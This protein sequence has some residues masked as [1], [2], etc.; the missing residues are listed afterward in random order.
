MRIDSNRSI[1]T[2]RHPAYIYRCRFEGRKI[3]A[4]GITYAIS[5]DIGSWR[6]LTDSEVIGYLYHGFECIR[7]DSVSIQLLETTPAPA[8]TPKSFGGAIA[9]G[10]PVRIERPDGS[11]ETLDP[12]AAPRCV[13]LRRVPA[14]EYFRRKADSRKTYIRRSY[15]RGEKVFE[16]DDDSDISRSI[17]LKGS[18][19]VFVGF[20]Y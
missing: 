9:A 11:S 20:T 6:E 5:H 15:I 2:G 8:S 13:E 10:V 14:G 7:T 17:Y 12:E 19:M 4:L 3:G 18:T 16:C 1:G